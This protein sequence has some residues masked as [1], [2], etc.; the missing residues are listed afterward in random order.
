MNAQSPEQQACNFLLM[1]QATGL[2]SGFIQTAI[3]NINFN[4]EIPEFPTKFDIFV[5]LRQPI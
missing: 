2:F 4:Y 5:N 1:A 3:S